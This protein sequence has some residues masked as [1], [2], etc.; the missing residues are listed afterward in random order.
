[1]G[2]GNPI[3]EELVLKLRDPGTNMRDFR[4]YLE[5]IGFLM[6][7]EIS[8][9]LEQV[10]KRVTTVLK[11]E[12]AHMT[13][14]ESPIVI[15]VLRAGLPFALG[16][17]KAYSDSEIGFIAAERDE[18]TLKPKMGYLGIPEIMGKEVILADTMIATGGS[19]LACLDILESHHPKR[20]IVAGVIG[21]AQGV[22]RITSERPDCIIHCAAIDAKLNNKGYILPGLGDA[23]DRAYGAKKNG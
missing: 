18:L 1:M 14:K 6:G 10:E 15:G 8:A 22:R 12:A 21:S 3:L 16:I 17:S 7:Y 9:E 13:Y 4:E 19:V 23:G 20:I 11:E 2:M 5:R